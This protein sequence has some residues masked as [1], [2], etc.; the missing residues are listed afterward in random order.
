LCVDKKIINNFVLMGQ[1]GA[2]KPGF[3]LARELLHCMQ[4]IE[5]IAA[6]SRTMVAGFRGNPLTN[7]VPGTVRKRR[8]TPWSVCHVPS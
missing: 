2:K 6:P 8:K 4:M 1:I 5:V 7:R 3:G